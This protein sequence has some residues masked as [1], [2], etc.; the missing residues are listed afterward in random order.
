MARLRVAATVAIPIFQFF[1]VPE[2]RE[3]VSNKI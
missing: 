1:M 3:V 2:P